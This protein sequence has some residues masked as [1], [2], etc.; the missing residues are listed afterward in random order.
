MHD[1]SLERQDSAEVFCR[2]FSEELR[3]RG[4]SLRSAAERVHWSK[5]AIGKA[6]TGPSLPSRALVEDVL[7]AIGV[8]A[9]GVQ[10]WTLR[11]AAL[12]MGSTPPVAAV[13]PVPVPEEPGPRPGGRR[14]LAVVAVL[15]ALVGAG[16]ATAIVQLV[17][18]GAAVAPLAPAATA[19]VTVQNK[20][21]L[22]ASD[23]VEDNT[24]SY[25]SA[26]PVA[27]CASHGCKVTGSEITSGALLPAMCV[28]HGERMWNYN[29]DSPA[30]GNPNR[31]DSDLWYQVAWPDGRIGYLSEVYVAP[32]SR[33][34]LGLPTCA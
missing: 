7:V 5:S 4:I 27:F 33:G 24:P 19:V 6:C 23:L 18:G 28:A 22:G 25:L 14:L 34:G 8:S 15:G 21:A 3:S 20:V 16:I 32:G 2:E 12:S 30:A 10:D 1:T 17:G 13:E 31:A 11:H 26:R 9:A 29:L